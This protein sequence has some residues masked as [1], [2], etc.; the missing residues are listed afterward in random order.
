M[1]MSWS[2]FSVRRLGIVKVG[3]GCLRKYVWKLSESA[4]CVDSDDDPSTGIFTYD[5]SAKSGSLS[6]AQR[7]LSERLP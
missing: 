7:S 3:M 2:Q 6:E 4:V 5:A 1:H